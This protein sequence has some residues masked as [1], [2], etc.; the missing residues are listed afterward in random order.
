M[1]DLQVVTKRGIESLVSGLIK[2]KICVFG[3]VPEN[4]GFAFR[5]IEDVKEICLDYTRS[6]FSPVK[7]YLLPSRERLLV[8]TGG[9]YHSFLETKDTVFFGVHPY[10]IKALEVLDA[11]YAKEENKDP[12]YCARR[13]KMII[14][15]LDVS[16]PPENSFAA[17]V[18]AHVVKNG[19][20]LILTDIGDE[21]FVV[22][23]GTEV[24]SFL[25]EFFSGGECRNV[26]ARDVFKRRKIR[27]EAVKK[28]PK[29]LNVSFESIPALLESDKGKAFIAQMSEK[30]RECGNCTKVCP[31]CVCYQVHD[32][33][34]LDGTGERIRCRSSCLF[35]E[36]AE[37]GGGHNFRKTAKERII[38]R[39][40]DKTKFISQEHEILGCVGCG[41][42]GVCPVDIAHTADI[43]NAL[44]FGE[45]K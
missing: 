12:H 30:C 29:K 20:D 19:F 36:A 27:D 23:T 24:G 9:D 16:N 5:E 32:C 35:S 14:I 37:V 43:C 17:S 21:E 33:P 44:L 2:A 34:F 26:R 41:R 4:N 42:C 13:N 40:L 28:Y 6:Y 8:F 10:D 11:L 18:G 3:P 1:S 39:L 38:N 15:G 25:L 22:E 45:K 31:T 7:E